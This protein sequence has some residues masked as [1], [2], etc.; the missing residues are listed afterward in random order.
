MKARVSESK[1]WGLLTPT[2]SG[3]LTAH[4]TRGWG[5]NSRMLVHSLVFSLGRWYCHRKQ[6]VI[7]TDNRKKKLQEAGKSHFF[8][9][10]SRRGCRPTWKGKDTGHSP[11][12]SQ[13]EGGERGTP[14][15]TLGSP[16]HQESPG[17]GG[18]ITPGKPRFFPG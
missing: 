8:F 15:Y 3:Q 12:G 2:P 6:P 18:N 11:H 14:Y 10:F 5:R 1:S 13:P 4:R 17:R 16:R 7:T 9:T